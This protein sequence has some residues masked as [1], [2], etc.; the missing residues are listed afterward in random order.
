MS[1]YVLVRQI[2]EGRTEEEEEEAALWKVSVSRRLECFQQVFKTTQ[3]APEITH[4]MSDEA[5]ITAAP[6]EAPVSTGASLVAATGTLPANPT[7]TCYPAIPQPLAR[8]TLTERAYLARPL[9][10]SSL[11]T[12]SRSPG[13][14]ARPTT[15]P[16]STSSSPTRRHEAKKVE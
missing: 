9:W 10:P 13:P 14:V 2:M 4:T 7:N 12:A 1:N 8:T 6:H 5:P 11:K 15:P 16:S 3:H